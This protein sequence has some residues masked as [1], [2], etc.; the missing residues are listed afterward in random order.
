LNQFKDFVANE[1][2]DARHPLRA[3]L[4]VALPFGDIVKARGNRVEPKTPIEQNRV[5]HP[6]QRGAA[7]VPRAPARCGGLRHALVHDWQR[8]FPLDPSPFQSVAR[9]VGGT[10]REVVAH[11]RSLCDDG[12]LQAIRV[13]WGPRL[14]RIRWRCWQSGHP[15]QLVGLTDT[16]VT[17]PGVT[18]WSLH[19]TPEDAERAA[20]GYSPVAAHCWFDLWARDTDAARAQHSALEQRHGP[21]EV[22]AVTADVSGGEPCACSRQSG[23]CSDPV[24]AR[25]CEAGLPLVAKP[26]VAL[27]RE[28][29]RTEREVLATLRRWKREGHVAAVGLCPP[30]PRRETL[31][32]VAALVGP[33]LTPEERRSLL[34]QSG[35]AEVD[36][37]PRHPGGPWPTIVASPVARGASPSHLIERAL[38]T[39]GLGRRP[40]TIWQER[41]VV[42]RD[43]PQLFAEFDGP[44]RLGSMA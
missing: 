32:T 29:R 26:F 21:I 31:W 43:A 38:G 16:L 14:Q 44:L 3:P 39:C 17:L 41:R 33:A 40:R 27:S 28:V 13:Q 37:W 22:V 20:G 36:R 24:L 1:D 5:M 18:G 10:V 30:M 42:T 34:A 9:A 35:V 12:S 8:Q 23:P 4:C 15:D 6:G 7:F 11:C 19:G 25:R 2:D